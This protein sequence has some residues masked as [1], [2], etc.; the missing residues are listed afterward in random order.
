M[1]I[2]KVPSKYP[3]GRRA[4]HEPDMNMLSDL[5]DRRPDEDRRAV[6]EHKKGWGLGFIIFQTQISLIYTD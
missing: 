4:A 5:G 2:S 6:G 1:L 3:G